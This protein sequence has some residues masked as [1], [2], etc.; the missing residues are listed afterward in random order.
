MHKALLAT[1]AAVLFSVSALATEAPDKDDC[2]GYTP[3]TIKNGSFETLDKTVVGIDNQVTQSQLV[4]MKT[5]DV[6]PSVPG[7]TSL[8]GLGI[9]LWGGGFGVKPSSGNVLMEIKGNSPNRVGQTFC[10]KGG[11]RLLSLDVYARTGLLG[12]NVVNVKVD[13][14][15]VMHIDP[16]HQFWKT[17]S[18]VLN[19][20]EGL[21]KLELSSEVGTHPSEGGLIDNVRLQGP[22]AIVE[23]PRVGV[24]TILMNFQ[25]ISKPDA[26]D[27]IADAVKNTSPVAKPKVLFIKGQFLSGGEDLGDYTEVPSILKS[28]GYS[29]TVI[30]EGYDGITD[31]MAS[32]YDLV[33]W[34]NAGWPRTQGTLDVLS[35]AAKAQAS[36]V[37]LSGDDM[38][39]DAFIDMQE[40]TNLAHVDNGLYACGKL[41]NDDETPSK[42]E[43]SFA[44]RVFD[45]GNDIDHST[46]ASPLLQVV[47]KA[48]TNIKDC[49][50]EIPVITRYRMK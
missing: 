22:E 33:W 28:L 44:G 40:L 1:F 31:A 19:L 46:V 10:S 32:G 12:D 50:L 13:G 15:Q 9:E 38:T 21:H 17:Y 29:V 20:S 4:S 48:R 7:W 36:A 2:K 34:D 26:K 25:E 23:R 3:D 16:A 11:K 43:V 42:Y 30:G 45:Y 35:R 37:V 6:F 8:D 27:V 24:E 5:W 14:K 49:K 39:W 41:I 18:A 47:A